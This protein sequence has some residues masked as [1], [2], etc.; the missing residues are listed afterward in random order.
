VG[1]HAPKGYGSSDHKGLPFRANLP[2][3]ELRLKIS[4]KLKKIP[5][6]IIKIINIY[7]GRNLEI[8]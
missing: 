3:K 5:K 7:D 1:N 4:S 2:G 6:K 8:F